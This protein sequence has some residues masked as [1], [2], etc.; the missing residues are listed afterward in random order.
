M[1]HLVCGDGYMT[2]H[3][4]HTQVTTD[5]GV[6]SPRLDNHPAEPADTALYSREKSLHKDIGYCTPDLS[7]Q[8]S[9]SVGV[10]PRRMER[11]AANCSMTH[12]AGLYL[13]SYL[14]DNYQLKMV[15]LGK[16]GDL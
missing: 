4:R 9:L 6:S 11:L 3:S 13:R 2:L 7:L 10:S 1:Q 15:D 5:S 12:P 14:G 16:I 8:I